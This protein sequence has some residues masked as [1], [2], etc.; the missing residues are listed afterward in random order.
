MMRRFGDGIKN[1]GRDFNINKKNMKIKFVAAS[2]VMCDGR[3]SGKK[4][5]MNFYQTVGWNREIGS[6]WTE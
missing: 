5:L 4:F 6:K 3:G 2:N 1:Y